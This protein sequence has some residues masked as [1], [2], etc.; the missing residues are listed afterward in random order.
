M[1]DP[2]INSVVQTA[3]LGAVAGAAD[4]VKPKKPAASSE[5]QAKTHNSAGPKDS[6]LEAGRMRASLREDS[7]APPMPFDQQAQRAERLKSELPVW[8]DDWRKLHVK[9]RLGMKDFP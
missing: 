2:R 7:A 3:T 8:K 4:S 6:A 1:A 5:E 9:N